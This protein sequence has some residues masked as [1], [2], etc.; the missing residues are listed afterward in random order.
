M[1]QAS[2]FFVG[3]SKMYDYSP[4]KMLTALACILVPAV[5]IVENEEVIE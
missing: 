5:W 1:K 4:F 2:D 3:L